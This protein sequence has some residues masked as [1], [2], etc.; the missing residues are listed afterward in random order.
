MKK[1]VGLYVVLLALALMVAGCATPFPMGAFYT[2][3]QSPVAAG[4]GD[5]TYSKVG[6]SVS[7]SYLSLIATGDSSIAAAK[8]NGNIRVVKFVDYKSENILG[9]IG[10]YTTYVYGD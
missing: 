9:I 5:L 10:T 3:I 8:A 2:G 6:T 7:K 1:R 4:S